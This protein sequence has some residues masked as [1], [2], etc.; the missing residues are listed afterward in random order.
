MR[1]RGLATLGCRF[2][3][4]LCD[5]GCL[6]GLGAHGA[7]RHGGIAFVR[8]LEELSVAIQYSARCKMQ[9][10]EAMV[11]QR[12]KPGLDREAHSCG[13]FRTASTWLVVML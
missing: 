2:G 8:D 4:E 6:M 12:A 3:R 13:K 1:M 7:K 11:F 9:N 5:G 10:A